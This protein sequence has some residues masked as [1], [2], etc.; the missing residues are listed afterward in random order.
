M[1]IENFIDTSHWNLLISDTR[2]RLTLTA[3]VVHLCAAAHRLGS[4]VLG[5][6]KVAITDEYVG[7]SQLL[8]ACARA[9]HQSLCLW[10][11]HR[12]MENG[13][14][15]GDTDLLMPL[16]HLKLSIL[17]D[18]CLNNGA[19]SY[20]GRQVQA[21]I[22]WRQF[23]SWLRS[24][25]LSDVFKPRTKTKMGD[26]AFQVVGPCTW[27]S[28][29]ATI[30]ETKTFLLSTNIWNCTWSVIPSIRYCDDSEHSCEAP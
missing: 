8:G 25:K 5:G 3:L 29:P 4:T 10:V 18:K 27:N 6:Q 7:V 13:V 28:L 17:V 30:R 24:S 19:P 11:G 2:L 20:F 15:T 21:A 16:N 9:T 12:S 14:K 1:T 26:R 22:R 23:R